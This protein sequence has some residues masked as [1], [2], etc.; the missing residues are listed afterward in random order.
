MS[1]G[2]SLEI[3]WH[4][5]SGM[6][7]GLCGIGVLG[8]G[9]ETEVNQWWGGWYKVRDQNRRRNLKVYILK[10]ILCLTGL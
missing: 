8:E 1:N 10:G 2:H 7:E 9:V 5:I 6:I 4:L 3:T